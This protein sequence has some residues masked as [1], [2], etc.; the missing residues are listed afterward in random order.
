MVRSLVSLAALSAAVLPVPVAEAAPSPR[1]ASMTAFDRCVDISV[2]DKMA[3]AVAGSQHAVT[4]SHSGRV[5][6]SAGAE[7]LSD[8][9]P[10]NVD[11]S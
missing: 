8:P 4:F 5:T 6:I 7:A 2:R 11:T 1:T 9:V 10:M 3:T